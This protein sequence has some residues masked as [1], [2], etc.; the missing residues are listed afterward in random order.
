MRAITVYKCLC[1]VTRL[2]ILNLL[3]NG[4]LCVCHLQDIL[5]EP[6]VKVSKHLSYLKLNE[7]VECERRA[8]WSIY[9]ISQKPNA[10]LT[11]NLK[12]LQ[13]LAGEEPVFRAD[14]LRLKKTDTSA[15]CLPTNK[16]TTC[17]S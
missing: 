11:Q 3:G 13:D 12:C 10:L 14:L 17:C 5:Q 16:S 4:P 8:N 1:D 9:S 2:R 15:A 6:Q 7:L